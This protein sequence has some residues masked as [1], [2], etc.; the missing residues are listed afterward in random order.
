MEDFTLDLSKEVAQLG[1]QKEA[2][3]DA[4]PAERRRDP[5]GEL[6]TKK[7][8]I[9]EYDPVDGLAYWAKDHLVAYP[10]P[11]PRHHSRSSPARTP[12]SK[13]TH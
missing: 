6:R 1:E 9:Q 13:A 5:N 12:M 10:R 8:F 2:A 11:W 7:Q 4:V 3:D